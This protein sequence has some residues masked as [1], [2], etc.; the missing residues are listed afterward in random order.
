MASL[1][2]TG[3]KAQ[4]AALLN[5]DIR[6]ITNYQNEGMPVARGGPRPTY[7]F[8][9]CI[10]WYIER[11]RELARK[12]KG[13][14]EL[15][16]VRARKTHA[17]ARKAEL[18]LEELEGRL[19]PLEVHE[20]RVTR[21]CEQLAARCKTLGRYMGDVQRAM[22]EVDASALLERIQD[23]LLRA[24]MGLGDEDLEDAPE[25]G[26]DDGDGGDRPLAA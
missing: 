15:D 23:D 19:V 22:T 4:L 9:Q 17:E 1:P 6:S 14:N 7:H 25:S 2:K 16:Q 13:L 24:L 11:E 5:K 10:A 26:D 3:S 18:E 8:Q 20:Q 12:G 21:L